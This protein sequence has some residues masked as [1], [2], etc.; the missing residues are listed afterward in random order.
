MKPQGTR[1]PPW[2][3]DNPS[4]IPLQD[5]D[6]EVDEEAES[7]IRCPQIRDDLTPVNVLEP[8]DFQL[9]QQQ[10]GDDQIGGVAG[11]LPLLVGHQDL[12]LAFKADPCDSSSRHNARL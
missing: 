4:D 8:P 3:P 5:G 2:L 10:T 7:K 1:R 12:L 11:D 6:I 9:D